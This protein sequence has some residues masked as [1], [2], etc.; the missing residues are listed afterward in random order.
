MN[1]TDFSR[2]LSLPQTGTHEKTWLFFLSQVQA[3]SNPMN[4]PVLKK[5]AEALSDCRTRSQLEQTLKDF[6]ST[7]QEISN[8]SSENGVNFLKK[9][10]ANKMKPSLADLS[11]DLENLDGEIQ[12]LINSDF[13]DADHAADPLSWLHRCLSLY[14]AKKF[15]QVE[16]QE[17]VKK[18][19]MSLEILVDPSLGFA[20]V[21]MD[22]HINYCNAVMQ[23]EFEVGPGSLLPEALSRLVKRKPA[24]TI[25]SLPKNDISRVTADYNFFNWNDKN[26]RVT[27]RLMKSDEL[28]NFQPFWA[29]TI[30]PALDAF[31]RTNRL[32]QRVGLSWREV[33]IC[34]LLHDGLDPNEVSS[35]LFI[36][37]HTVKTYLKR[38]YRKCGVHSRA[39]LIALLNQ[40]SG[41]K[42]VV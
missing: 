17:E 27:V 21:D 38:I 5:F 36:S 19:Q 1:I 7:V 14:L 15:Y 35:R 40:Y 11:E 25:Q 30:Q 23:E 3:E 10:S 31:S 4:F 29:I 12:S 28:D 8:T 37:K 9:A 6:S 39:Q 20:L 42:Y 41:S 2:T 13:K 34:S 24:G 16:V 32:A 18:F 22:M 33:E 26:Y